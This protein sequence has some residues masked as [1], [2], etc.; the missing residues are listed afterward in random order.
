MYTW[1][2]EPRRVSK[3]SPPLSISSGS[4]GFIGLKIVLS[5]F[6]LFLLVPLMEEITVKKT[7]ILASTSSI[8]CR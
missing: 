3:I 1:V 8:G 4:E 7:E 2:W 6:L 5:W